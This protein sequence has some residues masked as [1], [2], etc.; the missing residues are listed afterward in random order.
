MRLESVEAMAQQTLDAYSKIH[1]VRKT[2]L[3]LSRSFAVQKRR[4]HW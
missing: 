4:E 3:E 1:L 2:E